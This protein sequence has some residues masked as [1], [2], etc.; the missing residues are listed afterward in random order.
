MKLFN[1]NKNNEINELNEKINEISNKNNDKLNT[2][3]TEITNHQDMIN[4]LSEAMDNLTSKTMDLEILVDK[5]QTKIGLL[6]AE[7]GELDKKY[8]TILKKQE[9][10]LNKQLN[11]IKAEETSNN[12]TNE[13]E[14][15][16]EVVGANAYIYKSPTLKGDMLTSGKRFFSFD[17]N[18]VISIKENLQKYHDEG[19]SIKE[20]GEKYGVTTDTIYKII[21]NIEEGTFDD[22][23]KEY[24]DR[25]STAN[26]T[27]VVGDS[28]K[29]D[30][31]N[32]TLN[33]EVVYNNNK[34]LKYNIKEIKLLKQRLNDFKNYPSISSMFEGMEFHDYVGKVLIYNLQEGNLDKVL[35]EYVLH[36]PN[37]KR[38]VA[39]SLRKKY[40]KI[41]LAPNGALKSNGHVLKFNIQDVIKLKSKIYDFVKYPTMTSIINSMKLSWGTTSIL[42]WNIE[43]GVFDD[44]ISEW[45]EEENNNQSNGKYHIYDVSKS[46]QHPIK[47]PILK[48]N[49]DLHTSNNQKLPYTIYSIIE[50]KKRIYNGKYDKV[51]DIYAD[52][53]FNFQL[54]NKLVWNIEEG[55]FDELIDEFQSRKY[56]YERRYNNLY[57]DGKDTHLTIEKC[58]L[59]ID[60][61]INDPNKY[62][63]INRLIKN[64]P[65][66]EPKYIRILGEEYNNV[67]L[68]KV[69][70]KE[71]VKV[72][73]INDPQKRR[74]QGYY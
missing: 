17:I 53:G 42:I 59:I 55:S 45:E 26:L 65:Q 68:G 15:L 1:R 40:D 57:I 74:E 18:T 29:K 38:N 3:E 31:T 11:E 73:A 6:Q 70:K 21:Y 62:D 28:Y 67:N 19:L 56:T 27:R 41:L 13:K 48:D 12:N 43:E 61:L 39:P 32:I 58:N 33:G 20:I 51:Q 66:T 37:H 30:Y 22:V 60:C 23:I 69:L 64:Y 72:E 7:N 34:P 36:E 63:T 71:K 14:H 5:L 10:I 9:K 50:L 35:D 54:G 4:E 47:N 46:Y 24:K 25:G 44:L 8:K 2:I 52:F 16:Y 49:G